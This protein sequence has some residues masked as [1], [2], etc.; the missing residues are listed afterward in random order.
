VPLEVSLSPRVANTMVEDA[1]LKMLAKKRADEAAKAII[2]LEE[3]DVPHAITISGKAAMD[4]AKKANPRQIKAPS[5]AGQKA[6]D[7]A[8]GEVVIGGG[9]TDS[10]RKTGLP[11]LPVHR[12]RRRS[13]D[14]VPSS[15]TSRRRMTMASGTLKKKGPPSSASTVASRPPTPG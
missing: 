14:Y 11:V 4:A 12:G 15:V 7:L 2:L 9:P 5:K 8:K 10:G 13:S 1:H 3:T 6:R